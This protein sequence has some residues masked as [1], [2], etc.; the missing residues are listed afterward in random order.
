MKMS[1]FVIEKISVPK[2]Y[3]PSDMQLVCANLGFVSYYLTKLCEADFWS[4]KMLDVS[5]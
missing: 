5:Q 1:I 4:L 3:F 2:E